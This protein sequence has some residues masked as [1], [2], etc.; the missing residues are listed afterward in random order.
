LHRVAFR[1]AFY[2]LA[3]LNTFLW[4]VLARILSEATDQESDNSIPLGRI[5]FIAMAYFCYPLQGVFNY[6]IY[7]RHAIQELRRRY[8]QA[9]WLELHWRTWNGE[10][11]MSSS[12]HR[13][14]SRTRFGS[15]IRGS[16]SRL[17]RPSHTAIPQ[18]RVT[19]GGSSRRATIVTRT[20]SSQCYRSSGTARV[21]H[22]VK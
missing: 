15:S 5:A 6:L 19:Y 10:A 17:L 2:C 21:N 3:F 11:N 18:Q 12:T 9:C 4:P 14:T 8:P 16:V 22:V 13:S 1:A 20:T 7:I